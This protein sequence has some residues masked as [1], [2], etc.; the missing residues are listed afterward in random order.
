MAHPAGHLPVE[1]TEKETAI[2]KE[3]FQPRAG[4]KC[5]KESQN[6]SALIKLVINLSE[7]LL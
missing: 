1:N 3:T 6:N 4:N 5:E 7:E 2:I